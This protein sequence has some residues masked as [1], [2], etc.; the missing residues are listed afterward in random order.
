MQQAS[1]N[2]AKSS[3]IACVALAGYSIVFKT[4]EKEVEAV[5]AEVEKPKEIQGKAEPVIPVVSP[6][7][8]T[9]YT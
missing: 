4:E 8:S 7:G 5:E 3:V 1:N 9:S 2:L 6:N